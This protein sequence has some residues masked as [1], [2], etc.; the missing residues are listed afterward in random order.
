VLCT[1]ASGYALRGCFAVAPSPSRALPA[2]WFRCY[3]SRAESHQVLS[4]LRAPAGRHIY[5]QRHRPKNKPQRG[6][7]Y[8]A[9]CRPAGAQ[10]RIIAL[11][12]YKYFAPLGLKCT[13]LKIQNSFFICGGTPPRTSGA[14]ARGIVAEP[15]RSGDG[16]D[17]PTRA[18][19]RCAKRLA[20]IPAY[21]LPAYQHTNFLNFLYFFL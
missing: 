9:R 10:M 2:R 7:T 8:H 6:G 1:L 11:Y 3:P 17:S 12:F 20:Q 4:S 15:P 14:R 13:T 18:H 19:R 16:A 21:L 5:S